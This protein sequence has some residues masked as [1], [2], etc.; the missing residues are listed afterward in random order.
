VLPLLISSAYLPPVP[1]F[2]K[3]IGAGQQLVLEQHEHFVKQSYRNR[4]CI[5]SANG[6]LPLSIPVLHSKKAHQFI[7]DIKISYDFDWQKVHWKS[8]ESAYRCSPFFEFFEDELRPYFQKK[9][10]FLFELN[11]ELLHLMLKFLSLKNEIQLSLSFEKKSETME[12]FRNKLHPRQLNSAKITRPLHSYTQVFQ[13]K[14]EFIPDLS[15]LDLLFNTGPQAT[16]FL[17]RY[18][19]V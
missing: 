6:I 18:S 10:L 7:R 13:T 2:A 16:V 3:M 17:Q 8:I 5:L 12:D 19:C 1:Y 4:C 15:I 11:L 9:Q 14:F